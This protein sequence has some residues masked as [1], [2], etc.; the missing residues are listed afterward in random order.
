MCA[1]RRC[2][3]RGQAL[4]LAMRHSIFALE[5]REQT[6]RTEPTPTRDFRSVS[7]D[8][9]PLSS[10]DTSNRSHC[11]I[12]RE[13]LHPDIFSAD[14]YHAD[15]WLVCLL[16]AAKVL[17]IGVALHGVR[18][19]RSISGRSLHNSVSEESSSGS[20]NR[21]HNSRSGSNLPHATGVLYVF[22][23]HC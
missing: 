2:Q 3:E 5:N 14:G 18:M 4:A 21:G 23:I 9:T 22:H 20:E 15:T 10:K 16:E 12:P 19:Q 8:D 7:I 1:N 6:D 13:P 11:S 17:P